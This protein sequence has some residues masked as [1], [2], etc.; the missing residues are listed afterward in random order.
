MESSYENLHIFHRE[1]SAFRRVPYILRT[2]GDEYRLNH[3]VLSA[4]LRYNLAQLL[5]EG[6]VFGNTEI[7]PGALVGSFGAVY[8]IND[9][10]HLTAN[11]NS[12]FRAPDINDVSSFGI[13]DFRYEMPVC[14]L[15]PGASWNKEIGYKMKCGD[16]SGGT[17]G[18]NV[19]NLYAGYDFRWFT[20]NAGRQNTFNEAC[21]M[22]G[23][24]VDGIGSS[25]RIPLKI[26]INP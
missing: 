1:I 13:A 7:R 4:G 3:R 9:R 18:C 6:T 16:F 23:S 10:H 20:I 19:I 21:R 25:F 15:G 14:G 5:A 2:F 22:H 11:V 26:N 24:G 8:M 17:P 12:S